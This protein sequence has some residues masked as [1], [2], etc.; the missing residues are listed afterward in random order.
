MSEVA[1]AG[2]GHGDAVCVA[3]GN[4]LVVTARATGLDD[5]SHAG[6]RSRF[7]GIG[8]REERVGAE[9]R[10]GRAISGLLDGDLRGVAAWPS[11]GTSS[12]AHPLAALSVE[13]LR[14]TKI[15][16]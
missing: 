3:S 10:A 14:E 8:E 12:Q 2:K 9:R 11:G 13:T 16:E 15:T 4:H 5:A 6:R 1:A 7:D